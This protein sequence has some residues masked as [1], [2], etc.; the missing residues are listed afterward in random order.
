MFDGTGNQREQLS[1]VARMFEALDDSTPDDYAIYT[2]V[3]ADKSCYETAPVEPERQPQQLLKYIKGVG[4]NFLGHLSGLGFGFGLSANVI[5]G[6]VWLSNNYR[7]GDEVFVF[8]FSRGA[9]SARS[10]VS[11][12]HKCGGVLKNVPLTDQNKPEL[13]NEDTVITKAYALYMSYVHTNDVSAKDIRDSP[14]YKTFYTKWLEF[15]KIVEDNKLSI[16]RVTVKMVGVWDTV[17]AVGVPETGVSWI[18]NNIPFG[19]K[20]YQFHNQGLSCIVENAYH[21]LAIDE[22]RKH[23]LPTLWDQKTDDNKE[24]KQVWFTGSHCNVGGGADLDNFQDPDDLWQYSYVWMQHHAQKHGLRFYWTYDSPATVKRDAQGNLMPSRRSTLRKVENSYA[25][26]LSGNYK[27]VVPPIH[28]PMDET[29]GA[30]LHWSV[31]DRIE[32]AAKFGEKDGYYPESLFGKGTKFSNI[33][34]DTF[35]IENIDISKPELVTKRV[36]QIETDDANAKPVEPLHTLKPGHC[37]CKDK[38]LPPNKSSGFW[39][40]FGY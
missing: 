5:E 31:K 8:G 26:F 7:E 36:W 29:N 34:Q 28:R 22:H 18:D 35:Q 21:A 25:N 33:D 23:F 6:Y 10:L 19:S 4:T 27:R 13:K 38:I 1:N 24:V 39:S 37:S 14:A 30:R 16:H 20:E 15:N 40:L 32:R 3:G 17:G 12:L 9:F 11:L 2:K